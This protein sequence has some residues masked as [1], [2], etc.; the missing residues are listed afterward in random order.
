MTDDQV[1]DAVKVPRLGA[2]LVVEKLRLAGRLASCD[3]VLA[4]L[5]G[6]AGEQWR[7]ELL[8]ALVVFAAVM[9]RKLETLPPPRTDPQ[10]WESFWKR[11][12]VQWSQLQ[13]A[14]LLKVVAE[15]AAFEAAAR[16]SV[17]EVQP[18]G[19][20]DEGWLCMT[21]G[22]E[23]GSQ[24]AVIGHQATHRRAATRNVAAGTVCPCCGGEFHNRTR[25]R[26]HLQRGAAVCREAF[27]AG[28]LGQLT[29]AE[30]ETADLEEAAVRRSLRAQGLQRSQGPPWR[31]AVA[32][33]PE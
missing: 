14:F 12:P 28:R 1:L 24:A 27:Q 16:G 18:A 5:V 31:P 10:R 29:A 17:Y 26:D 25:L 22:K 20:D 15:P 9:G 7:E 4:L 30:V 19:V 33:I 2:Q 11:W 32:A 6:P 21:C 23:F 3:Q 13:R 8:Q